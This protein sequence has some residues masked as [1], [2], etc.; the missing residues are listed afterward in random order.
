MYFKANIPTNDF[1]EIGT[2][3]DYKI[4]IILNDFIYSMKSNYFLRW[5]AVVCHEQNLKLTKYQ[6]E[7]L[8]Q[9]INFGDADNDEILYIDEIPRPNKNW[10]LIASE[11]AKCLVKNRIATYEIHS[12]LFSKGWNRLKESITKYGIHLS[13]PDGIEN[14]I[15]IIPEEIRHYLEIQESIDW[16]VGLGQEKELTLTNSEQSY[17]IDQLISDLKRKTDSVEYLNLSIE[18]IVTEFVE[19]LDKDR[20]KFE[21]EMVKRLG[22]ESLKENLTKKLIEHSV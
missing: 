5:E 9:L 15:D 7:Q 11:I 13:K 20:I 4:E 2:A 14:L 18:K 22:L 8:D 19:L 17:R 1:F 6:K 10:H 16:L 3:P 12:S 21:E